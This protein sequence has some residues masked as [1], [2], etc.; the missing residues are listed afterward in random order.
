MT[1]AAVLPVTVTN[2]VS[3]SVLLPPLRVMRIAPGSWPAS[4]AFGSV[5][6]IVTVGSPSLSAIV[7]VA[8]FG[9]PTM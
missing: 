7:T 5:A 4:A 6:V 3:A 8:E 1:F 9:V 2:T